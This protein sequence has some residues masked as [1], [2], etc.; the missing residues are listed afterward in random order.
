MTVRHPQWRHA[1]EGRNLR[2]RRFHG[3]D[4]AWLKSSFANEV[5]ANAVNRG[6]GSRIRALSEDAVAK[7]LQ[8]QALKSPVDLGAH[9]LVVERL[10]GERL[11]LACL[12]NLD[13]NNMRAEFII[14][15]PGDAPHGVV[16][17]ETGVLMAEVAACAHSAWEI[18]GHP[19]MGS[20]GL[21]CYAQ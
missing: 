7:Q 16:L 1:V 18:C 10:S 12:A 6:F 14:G 15:F 17:L 4:A 9:M 2:L 19:F 20:P 8:T 3:L 21:R 5:F 11:G 13:M